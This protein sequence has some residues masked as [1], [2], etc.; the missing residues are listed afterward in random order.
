MS[1][2]KNYRVRNRESES[3]ATLVTTTL[4]EELHKNHSSFLE[5][6]SSNEHH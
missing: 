4:L 2:K 5:N 1:I 6:V 3:M